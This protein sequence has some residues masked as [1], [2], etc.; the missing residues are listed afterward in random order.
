MTRDQLQ[1]LVAE[2]REKQIR[3]PEE[4]PESFWLGYDAAMYDFLRLLDEEIAFGSDTGSTP[5][6]FIVD[7]EPMIPAGRGLWKKAPHRHLVNMLPRLIER[8]E[9]RVNRWYASHR[10]NLQAE[11][12]L[13]RA[14]LEWAEERL[15]SLEAIPVRKKDA[16]TDNPEFIVD[17][18][19]AARF[20]ELGERARAFI[21]ENVGSGEFKRFP[22]GKAREHVR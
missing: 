7:L 6:D 17:L 16:H 10:P 11:L 3:F 8:V 9:T 2:H 15:R 12:N 20:K 21:A 19:K 14:S 1:R 18:A 4:T 22:V 5:S 13:A